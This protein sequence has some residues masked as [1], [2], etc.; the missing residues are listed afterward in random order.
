MAAQEKDLLPT[1]RGLLGVSLGVCCFALAN[2]GNFAVFAIEMTAAGAGQSLIGLSTS[3]YYLGTLTASLTCAP[4]VSRLG[5]VRAFALFTSLAAGSTAALA[6][7]DW[8]LV[9][10]ALRY[11]TGLGIGGIYLVTDSWFNH[12]AGNRLRGRV[13][14]FYETVRLTAVAFGSFFLLGLNQALGSSVFLASAALYLAA[15]LPVAMSHAGQPKLEQ[16][17]PMSLA[18]VLGA[19]PLGLAC[20]VVGGM[21]TAAIYGLVP[22]YGQQAGLGTSALASFVFASHFGAFLVLL[23]MGL[24]ADRLGRRPAILLVSSLCAGLSLAMGL[25]EAQSLPVLLVGGLLVGGLCHTINTLGVVVTNDRLDPASLVRGAAVLLLAYD[26]GTVIGPIPA[27][28]AMGSLGRGGLYLFF[29]VLM[30]SIALLAALR[31]LTERRSN[32][33]RCR[34]PCPN[35]PP[36]G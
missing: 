4:L 14:A 25:A 17:R 7:V 33:G 26:V 24:L 2:G 36:G 11:L 34:V 9:W 5:H 32:S 15:F 21:T 10:P 27:A 6:L 16:A 29:S 8:V 20:C 18:N 23:P 35:C 28:M 1:L 22:L 3:I 19:A 12:A 30:A 13:F 31:T